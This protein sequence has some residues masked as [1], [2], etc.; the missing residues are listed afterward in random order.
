[1]SRGLLPPE[2]SLQRPPVV[3]VLPSGKHALVTD[4]GV[5]KAVSESTGKSALTS[6]GVALGTP[7]YMAPEQAAADPNTDHRADLYAV[8]ALAYEM[9]TGRPPFTGTSPQAV[10]AAQ[11]TQPPEPITQQR[12]SVPAPLAA[13]GMRS[14]EKKP[15]DR[16]PTA[17]ELLLQLEAMATPAAGT[18]PTRAVTVT[19]SGSAAAIRRAHP[20]RVAALLTSAARRRD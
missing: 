20:A 6:R 18:A 17:A 15:A 19:S 5:A 16:L 1:M 7:A 8:G 4:L 11:V 13:L 12:A 9:L 3:D 2:G 14:L 10:L